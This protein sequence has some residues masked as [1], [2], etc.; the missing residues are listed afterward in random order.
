MKKVEQFLVERTSKTVDNGIMGFHDY[1]TEYQPYED[2]M[3]NV[4]NEA[5]RLLTKGYKLLN[6]SY[7]S[8]NLAVIVCI[9]KEEKK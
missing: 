4:T 9:C 1:E 2:F 7:P 8:L 5:N 3:S 6:I